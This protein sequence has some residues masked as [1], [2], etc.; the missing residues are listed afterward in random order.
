MA[1]LLLT[2]DDYIKSP[3]G[4]G[5]VN[6][7]R[8][9]SAL[10]YNNKLSELVSKNGPIKYT[11]YSTANGVYFIVFKMP[12]ESLPG[13]YYDTVVE[14]YP[15]EED[16]STKAHISKYFVRFY[17]NDP[18][19]T[20]TYARA[21]KTHGLLIDELENKVSF[22]AL[23]MRAN[24][25]NPDNTIGYVKNIYYAYLIMKKDELFD[26]TVLDRKVQ[27]GGVKAVVSSVMHFDDKAKE[28]KNFRPEKDSKEKKKKEPL[29]P[30][31]ISSKQISASGVTHTPSVTKTTRASLKSKIVSKVKTSKKIK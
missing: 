12:S 17:S 2:F 27:K 7:S 1:K 4:K 3:A 6:S 25:K 14:L 19:F 15:N 18:D 8:D 28:R 11:C 16:S 30:K 26:K 24:I 23:H 22:Q 21:Y 29:K 5:T 20:F 31:V 13:F 10:W 9:S